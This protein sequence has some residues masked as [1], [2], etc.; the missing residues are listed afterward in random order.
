MIISRLIGGLGN[1]MFQYAFGK[2]ISVRNNTELKVDIT[3]LNSRY[4]TKSMIFRNYDLDIFNLD[5]KIASKEEISQFI[6]PKGNTT[7]TI[8]NLLNKFHR[9]KNIV[10]ENGNRFNEE[11]LKAK[12]NCYLIGYWQNHKYFSEISEIIKKGFLINDSLLESENIFRE[13]ANTNSVCLSYRRKEYLQDKYLGTLTGSYFDYYY[14]NAIELLCSKTSDPVFY[15]FSDDIEWCRKNVKIDKKHVFIGDEHSGYKFKNKFKLMYSCKHFII[16]NSTF[17]WWA[18]WIADS[19]E[20]IVIAPKKWYVS[21]IK[22]D[23]I[24]PEK[25]FRL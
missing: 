23:N 16:P 15:I 12:D 5:L 8:Y 13:I 18:A 17:P 9:Y 6:M 1:Q 21:D 4:N 7:Y 3:H 19:K 2:A 11:Y 14:K 10:S 24:V 22:Y 20:T 25:W